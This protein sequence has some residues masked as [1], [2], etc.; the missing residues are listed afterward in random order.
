[1]SHTFPKFRLL[2]SETGVHYSCLALLFKAAYWLLFLARYGVEHLA[3]WHFSH[4]PC[5]R[6]LEG[7]PIHPAGMVLYLNIQPSV[8]KINSL[9]IRPQEDVER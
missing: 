7:N 5:M 2:R 1:M 6:Q 4:G 8:R 3:Q 9:P